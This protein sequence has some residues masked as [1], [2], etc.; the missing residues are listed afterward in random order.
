M[1]K[2]LRVTVDGKAFDVTVEIPDDSNT[3]R[4]PAPAPQAPV[5]AAPAP[6]AAAP[7]ARSAAPG[8]IPSPLSGRITAVIA[9]PGQAVKEGEHIITIEAM[10]MNTFVFAPA[11]G[12]IAA[13]LVSLGDTVDEGQALARME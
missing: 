10:K 6:A 8:D 9:Q 13:I 2:K 7:A 1:I 4:A 5:Q 11:A 3:H 12:K